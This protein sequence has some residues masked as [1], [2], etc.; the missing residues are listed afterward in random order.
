MLLFPGI[1]GSHSVSMHLNQSHCSCTWIDSEM[2]LPVL[3]I[4]SAELLLLEGVGLPS[5]GDIVSFCTTVMSSHS[6]SKK[7]NNHPCLPPWHQAPLASNL[8]SAS[9]QDTM[10][11][12]KDLVL[13]SLIRCH[14]SPR[15]LNGCI[16]LEPTCRLCHVGFHQQGGQHHR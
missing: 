10:P 8:T 12:W 14:S 9:I 3:S 1:L 16:S 5:R 13:H 4:C 11:Q 15:D 2:V 6:P 7:I